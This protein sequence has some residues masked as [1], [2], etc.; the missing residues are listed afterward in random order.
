MSHTPRTLDLG[1]GG[2]KTPGAVGMDRLPLSGVDVVA[3][4]DAPFFPF[5]EGSFDEIVMTDALEHV[6][7]PRRALAECVRILADG[8]RITARVPHF[9]SLHAYSDVTHRHFF[10]AE[11]IRRLA[12]AAPE[13]SPHLTVPGLALVSLR[14]RM[15]RLWRILGVELLANAYPV[16]YEKLFAFIFPSMSIEFRLTKR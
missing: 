11:G 14:I 12:G 8:G 2:A 13:P 10:S 6:A 15:W 4:L 5:A 3:D 1:C 16:T 7:D 9:T